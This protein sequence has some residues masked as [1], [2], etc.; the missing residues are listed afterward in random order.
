[1]L[2]TSVSTIPD[3][4]LY[5]NMKV[6]FNTSLPREVALHILC[7]WKVTSAYSHNIIHYNYFVHKLIQ[8]GPSSHP[9]V[10]QYN[11]THNATGNKQLLTQFTNISLNGLGTD[12]VYYMHTSHCHQ[13]TRSWCTNNSMWVMWSLWFCANNSNTAYC[14]VEC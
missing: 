2:I 12:H 13:H 8:Q 14:S 10:L 3:A 11:I 5:I 9:P 6:D 4:V 7:T 1:M